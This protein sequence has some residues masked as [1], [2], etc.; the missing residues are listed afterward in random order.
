MVVKDWAT[1]TMPATRRPAV[2]FRSIMLRWNATLESLC[3]VWVVMDTV[4]DAVLIAAGLGTRMFPASA[5]SSKESLPLVDVPLLTHLVLEAKEA[6]IERIHIVTS[7]SKSFDSLLEDRRDLHALRPHLDESLFH[8]VAD[9]EVQVHL[10]HQPMGVGNAIEAAL[11]AVNGP[12]LVMLGDTLMMDTHAPIDAFTPSGCSKRLIEAYMST[13]EATV[14]L[15]EVDEGAV[16][17]YGIVAMDGP[18]INHIVEKPTVAEAP[19]R[20]ALCGRY[21]FPKETDKLLQAYSYEAHGD[22]QSIA[23][24]EHWMNEGT[25]HGIVFD[26]AQWYDSGAPLLWL[27]AQ[28]DHALRRP[29][30]REEFTHWLKRR[31]DD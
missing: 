3:L 27:K 5:F 7:P 24:L 25:L 4:R 6:G 15:M 14:G 22:L 16:S 19:S 9:L 28:V 29:D 1:K 8:A 18:R 30:Y 17:Q 13:G 26:E 21:V 20:L 2:P 11:G 23:L 31:L 10:Q 12:F